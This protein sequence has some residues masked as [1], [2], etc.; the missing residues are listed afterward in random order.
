VGL[1]EA[2]ARLAAARIAIARALGEDG[3]PGGR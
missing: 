1:A 3:A 2:R